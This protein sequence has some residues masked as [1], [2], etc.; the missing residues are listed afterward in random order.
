M[1]NH[2]HTEASEGAALHPPEEIL[3]LP[4]Q[5]EE[6]R[7]AMSALNDRALT[8]ARARPLTC[9]AGA[10]ALGFIVGKIAARY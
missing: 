6:A 10:L 3:Q 5:I 4:P 7:R 9:I 1:D 2:L 8:F